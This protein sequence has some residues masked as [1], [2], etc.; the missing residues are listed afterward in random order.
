MQVRCCRVAGPENDLRAGHC[1][2]N[3]VWYRPADAASELPRLRTDSDGR[4]NEVSIA[5]DR[6]HPDM[7]AEKRA[8]AG[9]PLALP[10][11]EVAR[12]T[13]RAFLQP[14]YDL[15]MP[16]MAFGRIAVLGDAAFV[17]RT[18]VGMGVTKAT[19][20]AVVLTDALLLYALC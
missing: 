14:I 2:Y 17:E 7:I 1:R 16:R 5:P 4:R 6:I 19:G 15:E 20:D 3:F 9:S 11:G 10:F 8:A 13:A 18:H 12:L